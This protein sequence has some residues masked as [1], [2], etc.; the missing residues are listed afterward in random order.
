VNG[1][2][3]PL[4]NTTLTGI[5]PG[6]TVI[7][8]DD[9]PHT[10]TLAGT[11]MAVEGGGGLLTATAVAGHVIAMG[12]SGGLDYTETGLSGGNTITTTAGST[13][14]LTLIGQDLVSSCGTD[15]IDCGACNVTGQIS[16]T[17]TVMDG[18]GSDTWDV[19]GT[20]A[21]TGQGGNP[22]VS[23]AAGGD[24]SINGTLDY[25][26][27][28]N[29]GGNFALDA[30]ENGNPFSMSDTGGV[31][32][33]CVSGAWTT[34]DAAG[35]PTAATLSLGAGD[36]NVTS[37]GPDTIYAGSGADT[38]ILEG[39]ATVYAGTGSLSI[40][41]RS[42]PGSTVHGNGGTYLMAGDTG[43]IT[44]GGGALASTV[45]MQL[46]NCTLNG[47]A[48]RLTVT[49]GP[50][51]TI[52]G[53]SGGLI[54][55]A[56]DRGGANQIATQAGAKDTLTLAASD[57]V[58][59]SGNDTITE[60]AGNQVLN[61]FG[62]STIL[63]GTGANTVLLAGTDTLDGAGQD[64]VTVAAGATAMLSAGA[65][66]VVQEAGAALVQFS[67][68]GTLETRVHGGS[69][70]M[71]GGTAN[72][73]TL[74][75]TTASG[76]STAVTFGA[77]IA[78]IT[79]SGADNIDAGTGAASVTLYATASIT[80]DSGTL[81]VCSHA[82][83]LSETQ[84]V[85]GGSGALTF[86]QDSG[87][88]KFIGGS[89]NAAIDGG[90]GALFITG[91]TGSL[92]ISGGQSG[93]D[94]IGGA[95]V[96]AIAACASGGTVEFGAGATAVQ[97][98]GFGAG[99]T[100]DFVSG[101]GGGQDTIVGFRQGTDTLDFN[102]VRVASETIAGGSTMRILTDSTHVTLSGWVDSNHLF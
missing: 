68:N 48:G 69:A 51:N 45:V 1:R 28:Q 40:Y 99:I 76:T 79:S 44:Y 4:P 5:L 56:A 53:G 87:T 50:D 75:I 82:G 62:T 3:D 25:L 34:I 2:G 86:V 74:T 57:T 20:A 71:Q 78:S 59:S 88:L 95:G 81:S 24:A 96:A 37:A 36:Y 98:A 85:T 77:G 9:N 41:G 11:I 66:A 22:V 23:V 33:A 15:T 54:Y 101:H 12:G 64:F 58:Y 43:N 61:L 7:F 94:F 65:N 80:A 8:T 13:N 92:T 63:G 10:I 32:T 60:G 16:G 18:N 38:V 90:G 84:T 47:G 6:N 29:N 35:G 72:G 26:F 97:E 21:I 31:V 46:Y 73:P 39:N 70:I 49:G 55:T 91:G 27:V 42:D 17:P 30:G 100:Y 93:L 102:G 14:T 89:G 19:Q 52:I 67:Q 83:S